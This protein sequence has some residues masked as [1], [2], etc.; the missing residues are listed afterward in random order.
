MDGDLG[1]SGG[2]TGN[3]VWCCEGTECPLCENLGKLEGFL[4]ETQWSGPIDINTVVTKEGE[5]YALEFTPRL[6]YDAFPTFLYGLFTENFGGFIYDCLGNGSQ[7]ELPLKNGF[8]AGVRISVP[9]WPSE[10]FHSKPGLPIRGLR[11]SDLEKFYSYEVGL[12]G[13]SLVTSGGY[14]IIGV[15]IGWGETMD[16]AFEEAYRIANKI[17]LPDKQYRTD[18]AEVFIKEYR[19]IERSFNVRTVNA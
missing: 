18:L 12:E 19:Q 2:C 11:K 7:R 17:R 6:G 10:D 4:E 8:A 5:V 9:P 14:G 3:V 1:P 15:C 16:T 13:D